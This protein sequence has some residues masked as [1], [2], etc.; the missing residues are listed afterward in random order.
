MADGKAVTLKEVATWYGRTKRTVEGWVSNGM[1]V[2][3]RGGPR[4]ATLVDSAAV[5][6]W[7]MS[8]AVTDA[9]PEDSPARRYEE[10]RARKMSADAERSEMERDSMRGELVEVDVAVAMVADR[11]QTVRARL[12]NLPTKAAVKLA[13]CRTREDVIEVMDANVEELLLELSGGVT[14]EPI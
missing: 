2:I 12:L 13:A 10:S 5:H 7:L 8:R 9:L 6:D 1:P 3:K 14:D 4:K 11:L